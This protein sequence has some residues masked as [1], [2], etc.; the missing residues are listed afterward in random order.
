MCKIEFIRISVSAM[1]RAGMVLHK[2][3]VSYVKSH[4]L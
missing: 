1:C 2:T 3:S 4:V